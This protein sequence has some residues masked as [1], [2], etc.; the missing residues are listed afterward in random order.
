M[1]VAHT[2]AQKRDCC[3]SVH[4]RSSLLSPL[5]KPQTSGK[6]KRSSGE[7]AAEREREEEEEEDRQPT[8]PMCVLP[9]GCVDLPVGVG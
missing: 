1:P 7:P 8:E 3:A 6:A 4:V 5:P 9:G 2:R